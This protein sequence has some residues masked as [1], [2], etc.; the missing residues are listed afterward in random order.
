MTYSEFF[1]L[2]D[3]KPGIGN[4]P[5]NKSECVGLVA[6]WIEALGLPH[7]WGNAINLLDNADKSQFIIVSN[8]PTNSPSEGDVVVLGKP[9]G[10]YTDSLGVVRYYGHTGIATK[11]CNDAILELFEANDPVGSPPHIKQYNYES[12]IGWL[13][14]RTLPGTQTTETPLT[15]EQVST[16]LKS[17]T[18]ATSNCLTQLKET[19]EQNKIIQEQLTGYSEKIGSLLKQIDDIQK[20]YDSEKLE[21]IA[22]N[23]TIEDT[24]KSN[25]NY[26]SAAYDAETL[27]REREDYLLSIADNLGVDRVNKRDADITEASLQK[28]SE[29]KKPIPAPLPPIDNIPVEDNTN[30]M[31]LLKGIIKDIIELFVKSK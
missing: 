14:A 21:V 16:Q 12:C 26:A 28:I 22:L 18:E 7:V 3:G 9:F 6:K 24:A 1:A 30:N 20:K 10:Q 13:H 5:E 17:Q 19:T 8:S 23:K 25:K 29:L 15:V 2:Y 27:A 11:N 4:T 31:E